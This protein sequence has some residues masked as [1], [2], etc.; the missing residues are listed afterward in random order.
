MNRYDIIKTPKVS[1]HIPRVAMKYDRLNATGT[2][3]CLRGAHV[4]YDL[5]VKVTV[6]YPWAKSECSDTTGSI[7]NSVFIVSLPIIAPNN[8]FLLYDTGG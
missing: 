7:Y 5:Y 4:Q 3:V 2:R 8:L 6:V 1:S